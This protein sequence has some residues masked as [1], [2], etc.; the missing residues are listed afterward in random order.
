[1]ATPAEPS[2]A[3]RQIALDDPSEPVVVKPYDSEPPL[4]FYS[5]S[6][7]YESGQIPRPQHVKQAPPEHPTGRGPKIVGLGP[8]RH[9]R[10]PEPRRTPSLGVRPRRLD[11]RLGCGRPA[12]RR[13]S[14]SAS[15]RD[16]PSDLDPPP[17]P[18][19]LQ[20]VAG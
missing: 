19:A 6:E 2:V 11:R 9:L 14:S 3:P 1:M 7:L 18:V 15:S 10:P 12:A 4:R 20:G 16:G 8:T 13:T 17:R 5:L